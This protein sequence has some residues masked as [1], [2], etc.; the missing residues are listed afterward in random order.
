MSQHYSPPAP[1]QRYIIAKFNRTYFGF[2]IGLTLGGICTALFGTFVDYL[3]QFLGTR[4]LAACCTIDLRICETAS[5]VQAVWCSI[6]GSTILFRLALPLPEQIAKV[7]LSLIEEP[8][9]ALETD[10]TGAW[11]RLIAYYSTVTMVSIPGK[12]KSFLW[13]C[14]LLLLPTLITYLDIYQWMLWSR[15]AESFLSTSSL[16]PIEVLVELNLSAIFLAI[17]TWVLIRDILFVIWGF[18]AHSFVSIE[19]YLSARQRQRKPYSKA[20][21]LL[22]EP[23]QYH[24]L[25]GKDCIRLI[26]L[27]P[28]GSSEGVSCQLFSMPLD[29][30]P[31]SSF[32][33]ISYKWAERDVQYN[34]IAINGREF[35]VPCNVYDILCDRSS[36]F[37]HRFLWIDSICINQKDHNEKTAQVTLMRKIYERAGRVVV[38]LGD[39][40]DAALAVDALKELSLMK[41]HLASQR[42]IHEKHTLE[43]KSQRWNAMTKLFRNPWFKR[44]WVIQEVAVSPR[45][46]VRYGGIS[47]HWSTLTSASKALNSSNEIPALNTS[48]QTGG[49]IKIDV[50]DCM[51]YFLLLAE[52]RDEFQGQKP[53]SLIDILHRHAAWDATDERDKIW[54][55][56]G[57]VSSTTDLPA[58]L[59]PNYSSSKTEELYTDI[60]RYALPSRCNKILPFAG[61]GWSRKHQGLPSWVPDWSS[62]SSA[63]CTLGGEDSEYCAAGSSTFEVTSSLN[64][65][66]INITAAECDKISAI[67]STDWFGSGPNTEYVPQKTLHWHNEAFRMANEQIGKR[68]F[69]HDK[70]YKAFCRTLIGD[71]KAEFDKF[72]EYY[73]VWRIAFEFMIRN[74]PLP[75]DD[76]EYIFSDEANEI[77]KL[78]TPEN[79]SGV[80]KWA[81]KSQ[82]KC[83]KRHFCVT[84]RGYMGLV[85]PDSRPGDEIVIILGVRTP[86]VLRRVDNGNRKYA[87]VGECYVHDMMNGEMLNVGLVAEDYMII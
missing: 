36:K 20:F 16:G 4:L 72:H 3:L 58:V 59:L 17:Q 65:R 55:L 14:K 15:A 77:L 29:T 35:Q 66:E 78:A 61:I 81:L 13:R 1:G 43:N 73:R 9:T 53:I 57:C 5:F 50:L 19:E 41:E 87:L 80:N 45:I 68:Y 48:V 18:I 26:K 34:S 40:G 56:L 85:P 86:M 12:V 39:A 23:Y 10:P 63:P 8:L 31:R 52:T 75:L 44:V 28:R 84:E 38:C 67:G 32:E 46:L 62:Q 22:S 49:E 69:D 42:E 30:I 76:P 11:V 6:P 79:S 25:E 2:F 82:L 7:Y 47:I 51:A 33:T 27:W 24:R 64:A 74:G 21:P 70:I 71:S 37:N 54:A 60:A 83:G